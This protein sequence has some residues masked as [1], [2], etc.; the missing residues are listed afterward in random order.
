MQYI[1]QYTMQYI[2]QCICS[3]RPATSESQLAT[4]C[5]SAAPQPSRYRQRSHAELQ[6]T[7]RMDTVSIL[8]PSLLELQTKV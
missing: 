8:T 6:P 1:M 7:C 4:Y 3:D 2:M 5:S